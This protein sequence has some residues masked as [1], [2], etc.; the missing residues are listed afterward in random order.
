[1]VLVSQRATTRLIWQL[2]LTVLG[3]SIGE[4]EL[5]QLAELL[6]GPLVSKTIEAIRATTRLADDQI[7]RT[8]TTMAADEL[9][10]QVEASAT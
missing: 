5:K 7:T 9:A 6:R 2:N 3:T 10:A 1:V 4:A 8:T